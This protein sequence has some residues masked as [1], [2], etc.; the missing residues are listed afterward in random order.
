MNNKIP[1]ILIDPTIDNFKIKVTYDD[2]FFS[3][4]Y[5]FVWFAYS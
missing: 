3:K 2:L 5:L 1:S 4:C